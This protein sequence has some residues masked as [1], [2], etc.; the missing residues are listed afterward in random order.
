MEEAKII[1]GALRAFQDKYPMLQVD[2]ETV[3]DCLDEW[4]GEN[5]SQEEVT[6]KLEE[7]F[8]VGDN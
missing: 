1:V 2:L 7:D 3:A 5:P 8:C 4:D 6:R